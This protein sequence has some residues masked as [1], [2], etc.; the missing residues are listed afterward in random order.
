[1]NTL[2]ICPVCK[3]ENSADARKCARCGSA[4]PDR[5]S[6]TIRVADLAAAVQ[7]P[8]LLAALD[9]R[10]G[11][12]A[13]YVMGEK[14][15]ILVEGQQTITLGRIVF[16]EPIPTVDLTDYHGRLLGVSRHHAAIHRLGDGFSIED[17]GSSNG[18]WL[19]DHRLPANQPTSLHNGDLVRLGQLVL[20]AHFQESGSAR[21]SNGEEKRRTP[22]R[23]LEFT[24]DIRELSVSLIGRPGRVDVRPNV[25]ITTM[26]YSPEPASLPEGAPPLFQTAR[27]Y[28][29]YIP[30]K[31]WKKVETA[32]K[33]PHDQLII[34][35]TCAFDTDAGR[36]AILATHA[37][38]KHME[39]KRNQLISRRQRRQEQLFRLFQRPKP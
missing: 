27:L 7:R 33:D 11:S 28:T 30:I 32:L 1:M 12:L 18:T 3:F 36:I 37:S 9:L 5:A 20:F 14:D 35:G 6:E 34:A 16:G 23:P 22:T 17:L 39:A 24:M 21:E 26:S 31:Q 2:L 29:V 4:L 8:E 13:L 15:P 25:V 38:T 19:N 10:P